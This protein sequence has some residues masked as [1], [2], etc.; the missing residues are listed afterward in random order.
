MARIQEKLF[1]GDKIT[2]QT[3]RGR[4]TT[5]IGRLTDGRVVLFD[6]NSQYF[7][8]LVPGQSVEGHISHI[9]ENYVILTPISEPEEMEFVNAPEVYVDDITEEL[10][11]VDD[12]V[13]EL[14]ELI[15]K[16]SGNAEVIPR[17]LLK[18][19]RLEQLII[20]ILTGEDW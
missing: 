13:E 10:E 3:M 11:N 15:E 9:Q 19:I 20:R 18:V 8:L 12:I 14:E 6:Q 16:V 7:N 17:A 1:L 5:V 4:G 2:V